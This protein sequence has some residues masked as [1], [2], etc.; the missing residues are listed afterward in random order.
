MQQVRFA[1]DSNNVV[2]IVDHRECAN[3]VFSKKLDGFRDFVV[4]LDR[5]DVANHH[6]ERFHRALPQSVCLLAQIPSKG[7]F[8]YMR[9]T[10]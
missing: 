1:D 8:S 2:A 3:I 4:R 6:V 7:A 9:V 10:G 5:D